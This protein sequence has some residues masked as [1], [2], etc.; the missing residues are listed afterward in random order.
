MNSMVTIRVSEFPVQR[1]R[2]RFGRIVWNKLVS[3]AQLYR[4]RRQL[5]ELTNRELD[6]LNLTL[7]AARREGCRPFWDSSR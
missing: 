6:D 3:W 1:R 7:E 5:L 4:T 2:R